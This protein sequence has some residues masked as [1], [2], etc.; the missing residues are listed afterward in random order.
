MKDKKLAEDLRYAGVIQ[1]RKNEPTVSVDDY[2]PQRT[3]FQP[4]LR[5][6]ENF[7]RIGAEDILLF[8]T[9]RK[10]QSKSQIVLPF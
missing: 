10:F 8:Y 5:A 4:T 2:L 1:K 6:H 7:D 9:Q 3:L